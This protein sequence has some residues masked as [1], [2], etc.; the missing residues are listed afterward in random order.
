M[1][2]NTI[3]SDVITDLHILI[4]LV[5]TV[6]CIEFSSVCNVFISLIVYIFSSIVTLLDIIIFNVSDIY[7]RDY[8]YI[9]FIRTD[10]Y[11]LWHTSRSPTADYLYFCYYFLFA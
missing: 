4:N 6:N 9:H 1:S 8:S 11:R 2:V 10:I 5:A 3:I 7:Y